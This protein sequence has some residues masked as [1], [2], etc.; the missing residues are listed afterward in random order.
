MTPTNQLRASKNEKRGWQSVIT[1]IGKK[2]K[3]RN[4][5][6]SRTPPIAA[7]RKMSTP[8][9]SNVLW[10]MCQKIINVLTGRQEKIST[11]RPVVTVIRQERELADNFVSF[12]KRKWF[13][14][15][16]DRATKI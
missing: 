3:G 5:H 1:K 14:T 10:K 7:T 16:T 12:P 15:P 13:N 4:G 6:Q 2:F 11:R 8:S 9:N